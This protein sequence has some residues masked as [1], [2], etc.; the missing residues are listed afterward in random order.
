METVTSH[1]HRGR[2]SQ[3][4]LGGICLALVVQ[5]LVGA[6]YLWTSFSTTAP[7]GDALNEYLNDGWTRIGLHHVRGVL[8]PL[9]ARAAGHTES[10][11][12][13]IHGL[14]LMALLAAFFVVARVLGRLLGFGERPPWVYAVIALVAYLPGP[15]LVHFT[16]S[17]LPDAFAASNILVGAALAV[18]LVVWSA[19]ARAGFARW[20]GLAFCA[21][22]APLCRA[23]HLY[24]FSCFVV[25]CIGHTALARGLGAMAWRR[26]AVVL[27]IVILGGALGTA[28][29]REMQSRY[30]SNA[31]A[32]PN[33]FP[34]AVFALPRLDRALAHASPE[35][36]ATLRIARPVRLVGNTV[37]FTKHLDVLHSRH[38]VTPAQMGAALADLARAGW[39]AGWHDVVIQVVTDWI[40]YAIP[41][42][43]F[44]AA[45]DGPTPSDWLHSRL[46]L[47]VKDPAVER[48]VI[49]YEHFGSLLFVALALIGIVGVARRPV[50]F[51]EGAASL[52]LVFPLVVGAI[53]GSSLGTFNPRY[54]L[55]AYAMLQITTTALFARELLSWFDA[56][57]DARASASVAIAAERPREGGTAGLSS[58]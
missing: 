7:Y 14:E 8:F 20:F 27:A 17:A 46:M 57:R 47:Q 52:T 48:W 37:A 53:Y 4:A 56:R 55:P 16:M 51:P 40:R 36:Q 28:G 18:E 22:A 31:V 11:V 54:A 15:L 58:S 19:Q 12:L 13:V 49:L 35:T 6:V 24:L 45:L 1:G 30:P 10:R 21:I 39:R 26:T 44:A 2:Y 25:A 34:A 32:H 41:Q 50:L 38:G 33:L 42:V 5:A 29:N 43:G 9:V 3:F 23:E